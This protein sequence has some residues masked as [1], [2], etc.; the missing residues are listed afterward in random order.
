METL[1]SPYTIT[2]LFNMLLTLMTY[3]MFLCSFSFLKYEQLEV[4]N[5]DS[6]GMTLTYSPVPM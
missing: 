6:K 4:Y 5:L 2:L 3:K 1:S